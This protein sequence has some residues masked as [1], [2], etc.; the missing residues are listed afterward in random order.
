[1]KSLKL[2]GSVLTLSA[3]ACASIASVQAAGVMVGNSSLIGALDYSDTFTG[4]DSGGRPDR[5]YIAAVQ[6]APTYVVENTYGH[7]SVNFQSGGMAPGVAEF[8]IASEPAGLVDG[9]PLYPGTSGAGSATGFTQTGGGVDYGLPYGFRSEYIVQVDAVQVGDRIDI[10]SGGGI[11]IF[12]SN[13]LSVFFRGDGSG[14]ASLFNGAVDTGIQASMPTF[15]TGIT[16]QGQWTNYAVRYDIIGKEI[17]I[18]VNQAS[19]G[20]IDL[21][22]FAG[23]IYANFSNAF[24]GAGAGMGPGN[25]RTWTD[26]FQVGAPIPEPGAAVLGLSSLGALLLRRRRS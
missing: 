11:G 5:P 4:T 14:N 20:V 3:L 10:S 15:N 21:N 1:M 24:V 13:S 8:S 18:F 12:S 23:G 22:S 9:S 19:V 26:N 6:S 16:G 17:E 25:N 2:S 7:P